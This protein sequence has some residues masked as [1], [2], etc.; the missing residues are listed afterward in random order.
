MSAMRDSPKLR[1]SI[2]AMALL[3]LVLSL[4]ACERPSEPTAE[5]QAA[6]QA[7]APQAAAPASPAPKAHDF[8]PAIRAEDFA[9]HVERLAS[10]EFEGGRRVRAAS[11]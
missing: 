4:P 7:A 5:K 2:Q 8:S 11:V 10:D 6:E 3:A 9:A 1:P